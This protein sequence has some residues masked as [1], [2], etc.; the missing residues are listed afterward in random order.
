[1]KIDK[2]IK[3]YN[4]VYLPKENKYN[5]RRDFFSAKQ[6]DRDTMEDHWEK[7][8]ELEKE[9]DFPEF[10]TEV[11]I[12]KLITSNTGWK[13]RGKLLKEKNLEVPKI[14]E[15][16]QQN[17][18]DRKNKKNTTLEALTSNRKK[19]QKGAYT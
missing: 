14:V 15:Q 7:L 10:S 3:L 19:H 6:T 11:L 12:P 4:R 5:T 2:L 17:T 8:I 9:Y 13:L 18:Y 16:K 1:M